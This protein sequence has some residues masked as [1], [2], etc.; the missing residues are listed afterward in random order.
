[1]EFHQNLN[2][3]LKKISPTPEAFLWFVMKEQAEKQESKPN[4]ITP[5]DSKPT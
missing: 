1:M 2:L 5:W 3:I 4:L